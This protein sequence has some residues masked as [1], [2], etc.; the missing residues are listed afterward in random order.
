MILIPVGPTRKKHAIHA[1]RKSVAVVNENAARP[2]HA[3]RT[4]Q[5]VRK[6]KTSRLAAVVV[7]VVVV[8]VVV[9]VVIGEI[10]G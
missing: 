4:K 6:T 5:N 10:R 9:V 8:A 2:P 1:R 7:V 3:R